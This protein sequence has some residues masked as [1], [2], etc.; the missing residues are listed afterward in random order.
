MFADQSC[1]FETFD[2]LEQ[3][4]LNWKALF[5]PVGNL[6]TAIFDLP[7]SWL[8]LCEMKSVPDIVTLSSNGEL[9]KWKFGLEVQVGWDKQF[10]YGGGEWECVYWL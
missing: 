8:E 1:E 2:N 4:V 9:G 5:N 3:A 10:Y 6:T 7:A